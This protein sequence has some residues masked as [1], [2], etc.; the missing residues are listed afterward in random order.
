MKALAKSLELSSCAA[1]AVGPTIARPAARNASTTPAASGA[2]GPTTVSP[3]GSA[4]AKPTSASI[5]VRSILVS[6][7]SSAVPPL[8]GATKTFAARSDCAILHASACSRPP[9]PMTSTFIAALSRGR[10]LLQVDLA[11]EVQHAAVVH[12][13]IELRYVGRQHFDLSRAQGRERQ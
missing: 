2:S 4:F 12:A 10:R 7:G 8:P 5:S 13:P 1:F 3:I 11:E 9:E 6:S